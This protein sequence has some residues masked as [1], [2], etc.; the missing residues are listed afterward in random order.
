MECL[1]LEAITFGEAKSTDTRATG[2]WTGARTDGRTQFRKNYFLNPLSRMESD[3]KGVGKSTRAF[4]L[5]R[6]ES[7]PVVSSIWFTE[8]HQQDGRAAF[9]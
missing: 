3:K 2:F 9:A 6:T 4:R 7:I 5:G 1:V 8:T